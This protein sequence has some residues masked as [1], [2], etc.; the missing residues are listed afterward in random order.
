MKGNDVKTQVD[1]KLLTITNTNSEGRE[2]TIARVSLS[3]YGMTFIPRDMMVSYVSRG[4][5]VRYRA[6]LKIRMDRFE[7][8]CRDLV[9]THETIDLATLMEIAQPHNEQLVE[10]KA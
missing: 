9:E 6:V 1:K 10:R 4:T 7:K 8:L 2:Y 3:P 5:Y